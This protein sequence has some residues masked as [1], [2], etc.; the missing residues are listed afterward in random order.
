MHITLH[1]P[2]VSFMRKCEHVGF[3]H[4]RG[5]GIRAVV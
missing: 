4:V 5:R 2:I 1:C 3:A